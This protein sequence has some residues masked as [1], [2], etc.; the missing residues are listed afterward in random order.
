MPKI[1][2]G[3]SK[4]DLP[5]INLPAG[6]CERNGTCTKT[7]KNCYALRGKMLMYQ[8]TIYRDNLKEF[9]LNSDKYFNDIINFLNNS[10][11]IY[12]Y[13][14]FHSSGD[15]PNDE[16]FI[17][18]IK[19]AKKCKN[20]T[21]LCYTKKYNIINDYLK[22]GGVIPKN[23]KLKFSAWTKNDPFDNPYN[24]PVAYVD[25]KDKSKNPELP[26]RTPICPGTKKLCSE[27]LFCFKYNN[28]IF[29]EH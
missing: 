2:L 8:N 27:C 4:C 11:V 5:T 6:G 29:K 22:T 17:G 1:S 23:L 28:I 3:N 7:C 19:V 13:F 18:M 20:T 26:K 21:F 10:V 25:F 12:K 24:I 9:I 16:Y 14:R 15:I